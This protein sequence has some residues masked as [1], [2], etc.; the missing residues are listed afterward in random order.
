MQRAH[1]VDGDGAG[2]CLAFFG[3]DVF[4][5]L[6][7]DDL[8]V[9]FGQ[10]AADKNQISGLHKGQVGGCRGCDCGQGDA[11]GFEFVIDVGSRVLACRHDFFWFSMIFE[12]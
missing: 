1:Q 7:D 4:A 11:Q 2:G 9:F 3:A 12:G 5:E 8:A 6:A 10:V